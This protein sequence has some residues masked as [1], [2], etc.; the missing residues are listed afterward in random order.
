MRPQRF[1]NLLSDG[2]YRIKR[3]HGFLEYHGDIGGAPPAHLLIA[4]AEQ[5]DAIIQYPA[6]DPAA[7]PTRRISDS[8]VTDLPQPDSPTSASVSPRCRDKSSPRTASWPGNVTRSPW[9]SNNGVMM[10][11]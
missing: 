8:A 11:S 2:Q 1:A 4:Q 5:I 10:I 3:G 6:V 9:I 7:W